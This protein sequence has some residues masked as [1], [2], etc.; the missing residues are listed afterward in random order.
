MMRMWARGLYLKIDNLLIFF[1]LISFVAVS[2]RGLGILH[3]KMMSYQ[4]GI[5]FA[6]RNYELA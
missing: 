5:Q 2:A 6:M 1:Y 4:E 3:G